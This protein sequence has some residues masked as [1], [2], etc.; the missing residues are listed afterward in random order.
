MNVRQTKLESTG[1]SKVRRFLQKSIYLQHGQK[2]NEMIKNKPH[3]RNPHTYR[4]NENGK[5]NCY[6]RT[7]VPIDLQKSSFDSSSNL[8]IALLPF[9]HCPFPREGKGE[10]PFPSPPSLLLA[11]DDDSPSNKKPS[12]ISIILAPVQDIEGRIFVGVNFFHSPGTVSRA[13]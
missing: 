2:L 12:N 13:M 7:Y 9:A 8:P 3:M 1:S 5:N 6:Y 4:A 11:K 10:D